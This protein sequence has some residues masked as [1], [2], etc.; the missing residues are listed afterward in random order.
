LQQISHVLQV[1][2]AFFFEGTS[3][4]SQCDS[5]KA[6]PPDYA[7][8]F[9]TTPDGIAL[10]RAFSRVKNRKLRRRIIRLLVEILDGI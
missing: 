8:E 2:P 7:T 3:G 10:A 6:T 4:S 1:S 9:L 5:A